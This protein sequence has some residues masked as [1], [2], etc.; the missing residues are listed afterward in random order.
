MPHAGPIQEKIQAIWQTLDE[1]SQ[2]RYLQNRED[3]KKERE[4][5]Y[6]QLREWATSEREVY[7][8]MKLAIMQQDE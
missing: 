1:A 7:R 5:L 3:E 6:T 4:K 2:K 8:R